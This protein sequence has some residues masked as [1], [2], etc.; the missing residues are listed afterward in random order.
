MGNGFSFR[1]VDGTGQTVPRVMETL[2]NAK[3]K[4]VAARYIEISPEVT[5]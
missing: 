1:V 4:I 3:Y 2:D 5:T